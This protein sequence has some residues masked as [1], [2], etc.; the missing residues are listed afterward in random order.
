MG[1][2][3]IG[4][5]K[6][7]ELL[8][9]AIG[10]GKKVVGPVEEAGFLVFRQIA[11]AKETNISPGTKTRF[12]FKEYIFPKT[13]KVLSYRM[14]GA[15]V[16]LEDVRPEAEDLI[17]FG[18]RPCDAASLRIL[19]AVF[20]WDYVDPFYIL[21]RERI[22][23]IGVSCTEPRPECFCTSVGLSPGSP[24]GS[25]ILLTQVGDGTF[26]VE[27]FT[28]KGKGMIERIEGELED[29]D[30]SREEIMKDVEARMVRKEVLT[31]IEGE[32]ARS[33]DRM[34]I[35]NLYGMRCLQC[36]ICAYVCPT[37]HCFDISEEADMRKGE[38]RKNW[39]S[40]S[41]EVFTLHASGHNPRPTQA[42]R[43]RQRVMHKFRYF[44]ERFGMTMCVG[45]GRC[46]FYCP[47]G[48]DIYDATREA[49]SLLS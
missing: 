12:P 5:R 27:T 39:D 18:A 21:R 13:E 17:I 15:E 38:R 23:V 30:L 28:E 37:C 11:D 49:I 35:W 47:V 19:D 9:S 32:L 2:K 48:I 40:C 6:I 41:F 36:G 24:L 7:E 34:E 29:S 20:S 43:Y 8:D 26:L 1:G 44:I 45:C 22:T 4:Y 16:D 42:E 3:I 10:E 25:D 31:G 46:G 14:E 33:F